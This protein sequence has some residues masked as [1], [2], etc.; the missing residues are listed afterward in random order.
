VGTSF[1]L[2]ATVAPA[3]STGVVTFYDSTNSP[4]TALG[5][6]TLS[7]GTATLPYTYN[8]AGTYSITATY[9]GD[10][11]YATSTTASALS[12]TASQ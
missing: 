11:S 5:T 3:A 4:A 12:I 9:S 1:T 7:S 8:A 6:E 10:C 2:T